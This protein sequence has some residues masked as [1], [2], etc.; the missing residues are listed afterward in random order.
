MDIFVQYILLRFHWDTV[1]IF[2]NIN[3]IFETSQEE[4]KVQ[5][6]LVA[7]ILETQKELED[8]SLPFSEPSVKVDIVSCKF[9]WIV[10][11]NQ[12][13]GYRDTQ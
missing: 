11:K 6:H 10:W 5:G 13:L 8:T 1:N 3:E 9:E 2:Q 12:I 7:Q 4:S